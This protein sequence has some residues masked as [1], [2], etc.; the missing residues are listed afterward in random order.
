MGKKIAI[1]GIQLEKMSTK[2]EMLCGQIIWNT[3]SK[4]NNMIKVGIL[5]KSIPTSFLSTLKCVAV[6]LQFLSWS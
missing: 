6:W 2:Y 5:I 1:T 4:I 3:N